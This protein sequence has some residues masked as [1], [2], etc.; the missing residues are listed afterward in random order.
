VKRFSEGELQPHPGPSIP[1]WWREIMLD[2]Q[3]EREAYL[4]TDE[5]NAARMAR[6]MARLARSAW[7]YQLRGEGH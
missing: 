3:A 1:E 2:A 5:G 4:M 6:N 7:R